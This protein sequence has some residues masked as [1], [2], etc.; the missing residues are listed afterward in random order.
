M[1]EMFNQV[2]KKNQTNFRIKNAAK[3]LLNT[4]IKINA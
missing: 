3:V 1:D 4:R 2:E